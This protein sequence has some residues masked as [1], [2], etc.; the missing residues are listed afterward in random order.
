MGFYLWVDGDLAWGQGS[1]EY[2]PMGV[3]VI[4]ASDQFRRRDFDPRRK[5]PK[6]QPLGQYASLGQLNHELL[7]RRRERL[8]HHGD[9]EKRRKLKRSTLRL[10]AFAGARS[11]KVKT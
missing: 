9:A 4:A 10:S 1:Y 7:R 3:A 8:L 5:P 6:T 2:R 11:F